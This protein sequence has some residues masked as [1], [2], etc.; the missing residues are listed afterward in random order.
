MRTWALGRIGHV[1]AAVNPF[2][3]DELAEL[4]FRT[5]G[6]HPLGD[7]PL[8]VITRG[9]ADE[10]GPDVRRLE[11]EHRSDQAAMA[12][13]SRR[14]RQIIAARSGH[15]VQLDE[16]ALVVTAIRELVADIRP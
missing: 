13:W 16:P 4:R 7:L 2:E 1:A 6:E 3:H 10:T 12:A 14:G 5:R 15:H 11:A 9:L 8:V